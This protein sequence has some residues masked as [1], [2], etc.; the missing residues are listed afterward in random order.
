MRPFRHKNAKTLSDAVSTLVEYGDKARLLAGG[1]DLLGLLK[2]KCQEIHPELLINIKKIPGLDYI[3]AGHDGL[4]IGA[5]AKL[6]DICDAPE[7]KE[8]YPMLAEAAFSVAMPQIRCMGTIGGNL[9]QETRCWYYRYPHEIGGRIMCRRKG[10][11]PCVAVTGDNRYHAIFGGKRCFAVCPSD[12]AIALAALDTQLLITG[13]DGERLLN[14]MDFYD[15]LGNALEPGEIITEIQI[16]RPAVDNRQLFLKHRMRESIDFAVVSV[17][18]FLEINGG[19]CA[20]ARIVLGAV[21]P[22]PHRALA[23]EEVISGNVLNPETVEAA[24]AASVADA[25]PLSR[26]AYKIEIAKALVKRA[27]QEK[28]PLFS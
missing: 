14:I 4:K 7:V 15:P 25:V 8:D 17:G 28:N 18:L 1:T 2:S 22:G 19:T 3:K 27:L 20:S 24:A 12:T 11:G 5:L 26:N 21:A 13:P 23:A 6:S 16:P 10:E 9:A